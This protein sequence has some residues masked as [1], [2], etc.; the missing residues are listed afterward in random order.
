M[1]IM[2]GKIM[3]NNFFEQ[4]FGSGMK[5]QPK[6][7]PET[8]RDKEKILNDLW[9]E[10]EDYVNELKEK[11]YKVLRNSEGNHKLVLDK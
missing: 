7:Q 8:D 10:Y 6:K 11:G 4:W 1:V 2:K 5:Q 3:D 9:W